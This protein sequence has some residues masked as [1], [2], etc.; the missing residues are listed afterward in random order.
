MGFTVILN[1]CD[2]GHAAHV[3]S[4]HVVG[5]HRSEQQRKWQRSSSFT[6][7]SDLLIC[8][9]RDLLSAPPILSLCL[10]L[11]FPHTHTL[12]TCR[13]PKSGTDCSSRSKQRNSA[14][15]AHSLC[16]VRWRIRD[17]REPNGLSHSQH[18]LQHAV[19]LP[20]HTGCC[21]LW[22]ETVSRILFQQ[23]LHFH[24]SS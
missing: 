3:Q 18:V 5:A 22:P 14:T 17:G 16:L 2:G 24:W 9:W 21:P 19:R 4:V 6:S 10:C 8:L 15:D 20:E 13:R 11:L 1:G 23:I 12:D 7:G